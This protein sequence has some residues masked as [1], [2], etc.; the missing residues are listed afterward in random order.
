MFL[1]NFTYPLRCP[2]VPQV[3]YHWSRTRGSLEVSQPYGPLWPV[4]G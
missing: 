4:T 1:F 2:R 3:E